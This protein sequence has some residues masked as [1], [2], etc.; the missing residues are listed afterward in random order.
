MYRMLVIYT[1]GKMSVE[2]DITG[3]DRADCLNQI[4]AS[5]DQNPALE[6]TIAEE[7]PVA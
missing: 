2:S 7:G 6:Y 1:F 5:L 3:A 4:Q